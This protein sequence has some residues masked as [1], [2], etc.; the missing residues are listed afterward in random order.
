MEIAIQI[1]G[2]VRDKILVSVDISEEDLK[3]MVLERERVKEYVDGKPVKKF[4][5][6]KGR[7]VNIV[8]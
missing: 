7:I 4:I 3:K 8:I 6:V 5:Y 2:K 1:N